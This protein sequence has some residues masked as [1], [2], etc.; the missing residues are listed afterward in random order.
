MKK[1]RIIPVLLLRDGHLVQSKLFSQYKKLGNPLK[2][3]ERLAQWDADEL[4]YLDISKFPMGAA[5]REDLN[6]QNFQTRLDVLRAI[7]ESATMPITFGGGVTGLQDVQE[8]ISAGADKVAINR[9]A[10]LKP[11]T[12]REISREFGS[13]ALVVSVDVFKIESEYFIYSEGKPLLNTKLEDF[14]KKVQDLG[15]GEILLNCVSRDG[16]KNGYELELYKEVE[17]WV[18]VPLIALGGA[19]EWNHM[20]EVVSLGNIDAVAAANIFHHFDQSMYL[21]RQTLFQANANVRPPHLN[22][23][24]NVR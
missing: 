24:V 12:I 22:P 16:M 11:S 10:L 20:T 6:G 7:S 17:R 9:L 15:A 19:G 4:I 3:V 2:A 21:A 14:L 8:R 13:Q 5:Q 23:N 18:H 1:K